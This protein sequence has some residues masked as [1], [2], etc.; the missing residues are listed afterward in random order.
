MIRDF[1]RRLKAKFYLS[2]CVTDFVGNSSLNKWAR[3]DSNPRPHGQGFK[4]WW[5]INS[6]V[7]F[8]GLLPPYH[9]AKPDEQT[10]TGSIPIG[11][12]NYCGDTN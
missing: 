2:D 4:F 11:L 1:Q 5:D 8:A 3:G 7:F 6:I 9:K 12:H 10:F